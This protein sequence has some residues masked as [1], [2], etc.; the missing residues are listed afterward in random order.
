MNNRIPHLLFAI[1]SCDDSVLSAPVVVDALVP[2]LVPNCFR[3][4]QALVTLL[5]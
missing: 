2:I 4:F 5:L 3:L 1:E